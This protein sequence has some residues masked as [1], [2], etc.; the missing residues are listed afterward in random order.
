MT[1]GRTE[2]DELIALIVVGVLLVAGGVTAILFARRTRRDIHTLIGAE[3]MPVAELADLHRTAVEVAG[4]GGFRRVCEVAGTAAPGAAGPLT[5]ELS[6][7]PCV[8]HR[9]TVQRRYRHVSHD[10]KGHRRVSQRTETVADL[11][12]AQPFAVVD[13][14]GAVPVRPEGAAVDAPEKVV[15]RFEP[16]TA[17]PDGPTVFGIRLPGFDR[18]DTVGYEYTEWV[19]RPGA[20]PF[21]HGEAADRTGTLAFGRPDT[22]PYLISTR[23]EQEIRAGKERTH[24]WL[25]LGGLAGAVLGVVLLG[26]AFL[27]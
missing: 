24:R 18:D 26:L 2:G 3:T 7:T 25:A 5:A 14:T 9:H 17:D 10:G 8:W 12:S 15:S 16:H 11:A 19:L 6:G 27:L 1:A 21:V 20:R 22:G 4:S 23:T 13:G